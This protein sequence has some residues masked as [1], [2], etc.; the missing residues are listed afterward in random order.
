MGN[1]CSGYSNPREKIVKDARKLSENAKHQLISF[2]TSFYVMLREEGEHYKLFWDLVSLTSSEIEKPGF[3]DMVVK[4]WRD[5]FLRPGTSPSYIFRA[6]LFLKEMIELRDF[7]L[8]Q[9]AS[10][11]LPILEKSAKE[12]PSAN[13]RENHILLLECLWQWGEL[14]GNLVPE[15]RKVA[16]RLRDGG[17]L[18]EIWQ[19][20]TLY[21]CKPVPLLHSRL[22]RRKLVQALALEPPDLSTA[23]KIIKKFYSPSPK[24]KTVEDR[25]FFDQLKKILGEPSV[26]QEALYDFLALAYETNLS[27]SQRFRHLQLQAGNYGRKKKEKLPELN[28]VSEELKNEEVNKNIGDAFGR[29]SLESP[30]STG[31]Y[32]V[33]LNEEPTIKSLLT[34]RDSNTSQPSSKAEM[35]AN[36]DLHEEVSLKIMEKE[37]SLID[38][39]LFCA[40]P[41]LEKNVTEKVRDRRTKMPQVILLQKEK[42]IIALRN[43]IEAA[44]GSLNQNRSSKNNPAEEKENTE[45]LNFH[46]KTNRTSIATIHRSSLVGNH[47]V[48]QVFCEI[49]L[50]LIRKKPLY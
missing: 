35:K 46:K 34:S 17:Y 49:E 26:D 18:S 23:K 16:Y 6:L 28:I 3:P 30:H 33:P 2:E 39:K 44:R 19:K 40:Q 8:M 50:N 15:Y 47:F 43:E 9:L 5:G 38:A 1:I 45:K 42:A 21:Y 7:E 10:N 20:P 41:S 25:V 27:L 37:N 4:V 36:S 13:N 24:E 11:L 14:C 32:Q 22:L 12:P 29:I 31:G 48:D